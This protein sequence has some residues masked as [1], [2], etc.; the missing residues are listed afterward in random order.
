MCADRIDYRRDTPYQCALPAAAGAQAIIFGL[1]GIRVGLDGSVRMN[2]LPPAFSPRVS[3]AG[4][5]IR[6]AEFDI[7]AGPD[8]YEVRAGG[9][10]MRAETGQLLEVVAPTEG[11]G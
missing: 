5:K 3:L 8:G 2:P 4:V 1:F 10:S 6:G 11:T 7:E 9:R